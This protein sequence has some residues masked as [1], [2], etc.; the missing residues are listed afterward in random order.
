MGE[1]S[2]KG[3]EWDVNSDWTKA[4]ELSPACIAYV[5][6]AGR[7]VVTC[8]EALKAAGYEI[9][10]Q[11][12]WN[13]SVAPFGRAHYH[14]K[15]ESCW[16]AVRKGKTANWQAGAD[17]VTVW[18]DASPRHIMGGSTEEKQ[19]HAT[20]KPIGIYIR[21]IENHTVKGDGIYEPFAGSGTAFAAAEQL[22]RVCYGMEIEPKYC[23]VTLERMSALGL[24]PELLK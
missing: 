10:Q 6:H 15:H 5:W 1:Q 7:F 8:A 12:I 11:I 14:W 13:K 21:P 3:L 2:A 23:A 22:G 16:Y 20:Q 17:Q 4:L 18:D 19:P 9:K 24:K